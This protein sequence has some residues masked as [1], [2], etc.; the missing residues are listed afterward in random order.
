MPCSDSRSYDDTLVKEKMDKLTRM[1]CAA[2]RLIE[3]EWN[4]IPNWMPELDELVLWWDE[5][6]VLDERRKK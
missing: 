6:K 5:H 3:S 1:L 4:A 2:C